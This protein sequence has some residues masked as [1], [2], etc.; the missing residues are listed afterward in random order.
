MLIVKNR[1]ELLTAYESGERHFIDCDLDDF[2]FQN[3]NLSNVIF[4]RC[5]LSC[6]FSGTNFR[7]SQ[8]RNCNLKTALFCNANLENA[9]IEKCSVEAIDFNGA[10]LER[11]VF[12]ENH[13]MGNILEQSDL[14]NFC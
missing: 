4:E 2:S 7:N 8:F 14:R 1:E 3:A 10:N 12:N 5:F 11:F 6:N 9:T 13:Y